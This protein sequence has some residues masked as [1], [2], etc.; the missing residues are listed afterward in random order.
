MSQ[1]KNLF[2]VTRLYWRAMRMVFDAGP[3]LATALLSLTVL[4]AASP[5][6]QVWISKQMI[7]R[8]VGLAGRG[9][10]SWGA[11]ALPL[12]LYILVWVLSQAVQ[13]AAFTFRNLLSERV[14]HYSEHRILEKA[15]RLDI[16]LF[17]DPQFHD[18]MS[19]A[20]E[21]SWRLE[22]I[23]IQMPV[24]VSEVVTLISL[25]VLIGSVGWMLPVILIVFSLPQAASH[26]YFTKKKAELYLRDVSSKRMKDYMAQLLS[27]RETAKEIRLFQL[28][29]HLLVRFYEASVGYLSGLARITASQGKRQALLALLSLASTMGI[30]VYTGLQ[31]LARRTSLGDVALVF[32]ATER[33]RMA[34]EQV[35]Y[36]GGFLVE[37]AI[38]LN[39]FFQFLDLTPGTVE[40]ALGRPKPVEGERAP[41][42]QG[43]SGAI[44]FQNVSFR[45]PGS[46]REVLRNVSFTIR[47]GDKVALVGE[48][49]AGKTTLVKLL[50]RLY[51]PTD[52]AILLD[53]HDLRQI[54]P[55]DHYR[56]VGVIF[57]DFVRY[58]L[59]AKENIGFGDVAALEDMTRIRL[60]AQQG[61]AAELVEE[62][63]QQYETPLGR[64]FEGST[65]LSGGEWQK[66]ALSRAFMRQASLLILDEPTAALDARTEH[67]V[68]RRF[69][70]LTEGKT[71]LFVT[72]RLSSVRM[73][74]KIL[75]LRD[76]TLVEAGTH[77]S[78]MQEGGEYAT[79]FALQAE[80]YMAKD[81]T[82]AEPDDACDAA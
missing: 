51:D 45:Y 60:A 13:S 68:Y 4:A 6:A 80:R 73:A 67:E 35:S 79:M 49:G 33:S 3:L 69:A 12:L 28:K 24:I 65:D 21:Q 81:K 74:D 23:A 66:L 46:E 15:S 43:Y 76:G 14:G 59:T 72:H 34:L 52:G 27:E 64:R 9:G 56:R 37:H 61:G 26:G 78:L 19:L 7:D 53:G 77:D 31:A 29:E 47:P 82:S 2:H 55:E 20:R 25:L 11:L 16:A 58:E 44:V 18:Q 39:T 48:N 40:G 54:D 10:V 32:Q 17:E 75:V 42:P 8:I 70:A 63:P 50:T 36:F 57:Q 41:V 22:A 62:L 30:W 38:F 71:T 5:P 1:P